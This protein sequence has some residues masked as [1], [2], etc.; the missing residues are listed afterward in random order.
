MRPLGASNRDGVDLRGA[1]RDL[2]TDAGATTVLADATIGAV[3]GPGGGPEREL[4]ALDLTPDVPALRALVGHSVGRGFRSLIAAAAPEQVAA[5]TPLHLL[6][7]D[8]P[9]AALISGYADLYTNQLS[10][11]PGAFPPADVCA[12]WAGEGTM[13]RLIATSGVMPVPVGP[14]APALEPDDPLAWHDVPVLAG[15][16]MRRRRLVDVTA[17]EVLTVRA[18]FRDSY[19]TADGV[20]QVLHEYALE[21]A[22]EPA[23]GTVTRCVATPRALPWPECPLAAASAGELVGHPV[24]EIR[25]FV[26]RNM[27][28]TRTCT[29]LNDLLRSVTDVV[30]LARALGHYNG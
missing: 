14:P 16:A 19:L 25:E 1:A 8:L 15:G 26:R 9:V 21:A 29:H 18:M 23:G 27:R 12:G 17:G 11:A 3:L 22:V 5:Q 6:V 24:A 20:E 4:R 28:G 13:M 10:S 30:P 7:D 2:R